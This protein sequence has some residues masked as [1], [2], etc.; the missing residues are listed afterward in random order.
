MSVYKRTLWGLVKSLFLAVCGGVFLI[1]AAWW[2][3]SDIRIVLGIAAVFILFMGYSVFFGENIKFELDNG[4]LRYYQKGRLKNDFDLRTCS[5]RYYIRSDMSFPPTHDIMLYV[6][7]LGRDDEISIDASPIGKRK[8]DRMF[9][10]MEKAM[11]NA[12]EILETKP[13]KIGRIETTK[14]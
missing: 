5:V 12:I 7:E 2:F 3:L 4:R 11:P 9:E 6:T 14:K 10:E 8:F 1:G 13:E